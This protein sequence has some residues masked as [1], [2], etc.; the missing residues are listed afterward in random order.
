MRILITNTES[1]GMGSF[2]VANAILHELL[3]RGHQAILFFP[4]TG[5]MTHDIDYYYNHKEIYKIWKFPI[6]DH[7]TEIQSF[8]LIIPDLHPRSTDHKTFK[9]LSDRELQCYFHSLRH[10][11][12]HLIDQFNPHIIEC[13]HIWTMNKIV[14]ETNVPFICTA[15][16]TDQLGFDYDSRMHLIA[17]EAAQRAE[18]LIA[19]SDYVKNELIA[20]YHAPPKKIHMIANG[21]NKDIFFKKEVDRK[22]LLHQL[23]LDIPDNATLF[24][25]SGMISKTK[26]VDLI[27][28]ANRLLSSDANIHFLILGA[29]H[30]DDVID[31]SDAAI[32]SFERVHFLGYQPMQQLS[33]IYNCC[34]F[35]LLPSRD[36]GFGIAALELMACGLPMIA[37]RV[38]GLQEL[39]IG[40]LI[41]SGREEEL[42][43]ALIDCSQWPQEKREAISKKAMQKA[44]SFSWEKAVDQR[45]KLY[46]SILRN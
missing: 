33:A 22:Q 2:S 41:H 23:H 19:V 37:T 29:G 11:L 24:C 44:A 14:Q 40:T 36:E 7:Q 6:S 8:P 9:E 42:A 16:H 35:G 1:W 12:H 21:Y 20:Q 28:K 43:Q 32:Y 38:G 26:G 45:L 15:H 18:A 4:D 31:P 17:K 27:L 30:I 46:E 34:D 5:L 3:K 39:A 13:Q 10:E 25:F